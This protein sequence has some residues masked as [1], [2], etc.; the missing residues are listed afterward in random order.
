MVERER[1]RERERTLRKF[2]NNGREKER[3]GENAVNSWGG[4]I[5]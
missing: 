5:Q 4:G 3:K 1:E 2:T